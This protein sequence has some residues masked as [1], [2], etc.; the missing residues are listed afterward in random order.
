M[1]VAYSLAASVTPVLK[2]GMVPTTCRAFPEIKIQAARCVFLPCSRSW[3]AE[4]ELVGHAS[5][6]HRALDAEQELVDSIV[7]FAPE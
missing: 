2:C 4:Q 7:L 6:M 5:G 1:F 3:D